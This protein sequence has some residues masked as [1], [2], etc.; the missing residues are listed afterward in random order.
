MS[1]VEAV[2][3]PLYEQ[4]PLP[5]SETQLKP[6]AFNLSREYERAQ[7]LQEKGLPFFI[8]QAEYYAKET[9]GK[10]KVDEFEHRI[11]RDENGNVHLVFG[12]DDQLAE[13]SYAKPVSNPALPL[14]YRK[15]AQHDVKWTYMMQN[16][17]SKAKV[18]DR[19]F[20][21]SPTAFSIP[22]EER[23]KSGFGL[24]SFASVSEL[25][26]EDGVEKLVTR[27]IRNYLD[28]QEHELLFALVTG[29]HVDRQFLPR[30]VGK[31][32]D[33]IQIGHIEQIIEGLYDNTPPERKIIPD[34][35]DAMIKTAEEMKALLSPFE[36]WLRGIYYLMQDGEDPYIIQEQFRGW[37][38]V[39]KAA[40]AGEHVDTEFFQR[41]NPR[42]LLYYSLSSGPS[43]IS[44]YTARE[45]VAG[46]NFCGDGAGFSSTVDRQDGPMT[47]GTMTENSEKCPEIKCGK[48][49]CGWKADED[50]I[51]K[52]RLGRM[53]ACPKCGW[54]P[55]G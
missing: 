45:Y 20:D 3:Y 2:S 25:V 16:E 40:V 11:K 30:T 19:F 32:P 43:P 7:E 42:S 54:K 27:P 47:Y 37:E 18:G 8:S 4:Q 51:R 48:E 55:K 39:I 13:E 5:P 46:D 10:V 15:I 44:E 9:Y 14:W 34:E 6:F 24:H 1:I 41:L 33:H 36:N 53:T 38:K 49:G 52:I 29:K 17:L 22:L 35:D 21:V 12:P 23:K 28:E 50:D 26:V 31:I